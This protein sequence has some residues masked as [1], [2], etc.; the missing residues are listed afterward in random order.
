[1]KF[2]SCKFKYF[3]KI[4]RTRTSL[5]FE[6][7]A[8]QTEMH[9]LIRMCVKN[10]ISNLWLEEATYCFAN[11]MI[12]ILYRAYLVNCTPKGY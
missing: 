11:S 10:T 9:V 7:E 12:H 3:N 4:K 5:K 8:T 2:E 1:M 6:F